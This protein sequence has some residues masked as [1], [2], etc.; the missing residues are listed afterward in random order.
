MNA[1]ER[2]DGTPRGRITLSPQQKQEGFAAVMRGLA[3]RSEQERTQLREYADAAVRG[4]EA[5]RMGQELL[6][7]G[8]YAEAVPWLETAARCRVPGAE[9]ALDTAVRAA[10]P[11]TRRLTQGEAAAY[12]AG[13]A[14]QLFT[15]PGTRHT[16][17]SAEPDPSA[18]AGNTARAARPIKNLRNGMW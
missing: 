8:R 3:G 17:G 2:P 1:V 10:G 13:A 5:Y 18:P 12:E 14:D 6:E 15:D 11:D 7:S 9:E 16:H 4:Y